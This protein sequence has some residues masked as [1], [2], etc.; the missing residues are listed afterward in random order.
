MPFT[1][2]FNGSFF[3]ME[4]LPRTRSTRFVR[5]DGKRIDVSG[6][7]LSIDGFSL[8]AGSAGFPSVQ[9]K[10][11]A[12]AYLLSP[13]DTDVDRRRRP[14]RPAPRAPPPAAARAVTTPAASEVT[15]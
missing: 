6:R 11:A 9:A 5:V 4:Q 1:F 12:T 14:R 2:L 13:D 8:A 15:R 7:L 3:D 10:I